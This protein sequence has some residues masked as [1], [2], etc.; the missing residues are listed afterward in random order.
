MTEPERT[1]PAQA[2]RDYDADVLIVGMGPTGAALAGLLG[3]HGIRTAVFDKLPGLYPLPRAAGMDHEVMRIAQE[4]Q[5]AEALQRHVV[6]YRASEYHGVD[7]QVIKRLDSPPPPHRLGW[8]P[9][10]AFDQPAFENL[11]R[12]RVAALPSVTVSLGCTVSRIGQD[13]EHAWVDVQRADTTTIER[14]TGRYLVG[15]DGGSSPVRQALGIT[16]TDL[17]FH[18]DFLVVDAIVGDEALSRLPAT[19]VQY[20]E[21][22]RPS[23]F[24]VLAG[25][26]RRW[27]IMLNPGELVP[28]AVTDAEAWPFLERWIKPGDAELWRSAA[29]TFHGLVADQWRSG[30]ILLA[31]DAAHMTPPFMAQG[32]AQ[33]MRDAQNLA[34]KLRHALMAPTA[35]PDLLDSYQLERRPHVIATTGHTIDLGRVICERDFN[36]A[37]AR[38]IELRGADDTAVPVTYRSTFLPPLADGLIATHT[39]GAGQILP[40]PRVLVPGGGSVLLDEQSGCGFRVITSAEVNPDDIA[41]LTKSIAPLDG[42]VIRLLP[43]NSVPTE[44]PCTVIEADNLLTSWLTDLN[45]TIVIARPD[46]IV[47]GTAASTDE[48]QTLI[49]ELLTHLGS[50]MESRHG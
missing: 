46:H 21:P 6:P 25:H 50:H 8:D 40:Q 10:Y 36:K 7:G 47:Y 19:Q 39:A 43:R 30:R 3:Q 31:G 28:G 41:A 26:H 18:E 14:V 17:E 33:G 13:E 48:C 44:E 4:L 22:E 49:A 20:C 42:S 37:R 24:V 16:L 5:I 29:Y 32:M 27:E 11:L 45:R 9:M 12:E 23:T 1:R 35:V 15:C 38:D 34:W 2:G